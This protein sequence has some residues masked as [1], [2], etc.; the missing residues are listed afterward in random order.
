MAGKR[1]RK[2]R[3]KSEDLLSKINARHEKLNRLIM[4]ERDPVE[5]YS[6]RAIDTKTAVDKEIVRIEQESFKA[7]FFTSIYSD[8]HPVTLKNKNNE[9]RIINFPGDFVHAAEMGKG[10]LFLGIGDP[11]GHGTESN[12]L[13]NPDLYR[14]NLWMREVLD[15]LTPSFQKKRKSRRQKG[16]DPSA[17]L[18]DFGT[19]L[20]NAYK[21][22]EEEGGVI[23][24]QAQ[25]FHLMRYPFVKGKRF[26]PKK[27][28]VLVSCANF[29]SEF[30]VVKGEDIQRV[31]SGETLKPEFE[32]ANPKLKGQDLGGNTMLGVHEGEVKITQLSFEAGDH[33]EPTFLIAGSDGIWEARDDDTKKIFFRTI[34]QK[35]L[36]GICLKH[37]NNPSQI[38]AEVKKLLKKH[39]KINDDD[40]TLSI[41]KLA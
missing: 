19:Y 3:V 4:K 18:A 20:N 39:I 15:H 7:G 14:T 21:R 22:A 8:G 17:F 16:T 11:Q 27:H 13:P 24:G 37:P 10:E 31:G 1:D 26:N 30:F 9:K 36:P 6:Q 23:L 32:S 41:V 25:F 38:L 2:Y 33:A 35:E 28:R 12:G 34:L 40:N 29:G 5:F